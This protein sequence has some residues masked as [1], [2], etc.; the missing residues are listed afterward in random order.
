MPPIGMIVEKGKCVRLLW[1]P[2]QLPQI[3][4]LKPHPFIIS[5]FCGSQVWVAC[6][7]LCLGS[8]EAEI[9]LLAM[10]GSDSEAVGKNLLP[11]SLWLLAEFIFL[12]F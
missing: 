2:E 11:S 7:V 10:V 3:S 4:G 6:S 5:W 12:Q 9:K 1:V 8:H